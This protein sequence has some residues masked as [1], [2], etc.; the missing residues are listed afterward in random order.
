MKSGCYCRSFIRENQSSF[1]LL[2]VIIPV[3]NVETTL[4]ECVDS[5]LGQ[6]VSGMEVI[7]VDDG[8]PDDCP[9]ICDELAAHDSRIRVVHKANG[10]LSSARNAGLD[11]ATGVWVTFVDS[12]DRVEAGTYAPLMDYL[13][14]HDDCDMLEFPLRHEGVTRVTPRIDE[15]VFDSGRHYWYA[16]MAWQHS[17][18]WNKIYRRRLFHNIRFPVGKVFE[19]L[20]TLPRLLCHC[21]EVRTLP[22]GHYVYRWNEQGIS[23]I[24]SRTAR[25]AYSNLIALLSAARTMRMWPWQPRNGNIYYMMLCRIVDMIKCTATRKDTVNGV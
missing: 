10:G 7:L 18:A 5:V 9:M 14:Q 2:T 17:Y 11:I 19:D 16:T 22:V 25:G 21:G 8:S 13:L 1:M 3:Y 4:R 15:A 20:R 24:A 23:V 6:C 12:D